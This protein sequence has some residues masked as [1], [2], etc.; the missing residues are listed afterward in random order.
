M[1]I[2]L[3]KNGGFIYA[4]HTGLVSDSERKKA[5]VVY[6]ELQ[7]SIPAL[8]KKLLKNQLLTRKGKKKDAL[9]VWFEFGTLL[10]Q[11]ADKYNIIGTSDEEFFWQSIYDHVSPIVQKGPMPKRSKNWKQNHFRLCALMTRKRSWRSVE[12]VGNWSIWREIFDNKKILEDERLFNW[13]INEITKLR[14]RGL[15]HKKIRPFLYEISKRFKNIDTNLLTNK[16]LKI[17][18]QDINMR[19][20][21]NAQKVGQN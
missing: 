20:Y 15:G 8:E 2:K 10:N 9:R 13:T 14:K 19:K 3:K 4:S 21:K 12:G 17:K 1:A 5:D 16:E 7:K 11:I 6:K 18:L